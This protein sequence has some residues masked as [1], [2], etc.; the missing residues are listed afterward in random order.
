MNLYIV[1]EHSGTAQR[2]S[3]LL[4]GATVSD[5]PPIEP[6][7]VLLRW[8][9][10][11]GSDQAT[12]VLNPL[13]AIEASR[14]QHHVASL[15]RV[16]RIPATAVTSATARYRVYIFDLR[17]FG[18]TRRSGR[19]WRLVRPGRKLLER[20]VIPARR[21]MYSLGL[22]GGCVEIGFINQRA[23][24]VRVSAG[25]ALGSTLSQRLARAVQQYIDERRYDPT[26]RTIVLGADPEFIMRSRRTGRII[27]ANRF[28]PYRGPVGHDRLL[29]KSL[30]GRPLAELRPSPSTEPE[31]LFRNLQNGI[32]RAMRRTGRRVEFTA[33]SLPFAQFPIGGHVHFSGVSLTAHFLRALDIYLAIP[34][35]L[36]DNPAR[37]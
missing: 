14:Y 27:T 35:M 34:L 5:K 37:S 13:R 16:N 1:C 20:L 6:V 33:G 9:G 3:A 22:H 26:G 2:L 7:D 32:R 15:L 21:A 36:I 17:S 25:P 31:Q 8:G 4:P 10:T 30:G 19:A 23:T 18:I 12:W 11:S 29:A 28:F 24:I